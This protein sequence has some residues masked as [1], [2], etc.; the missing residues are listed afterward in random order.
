MLEDIRRNAKITLQGNVINCFSKQFSVFLSLL[1]F[2]LSSIVCVWFLIIDTAPLASIG[3]F[4]NIFLHIAV[5]AFAVMENLILFSVY[6]YSKLKADAYFY[7]LVCPC[8]FTL[9]LKTVV[10]YFSVFLAEKI[11]KISAFV[12]FFLPCGVVFHLAVKMLGTGVSKAIFAILIS[13]FCILLSLSVYSYSVFIC[14]YGMLTFVVLSDADLSVSEIFRTSQKLTNGKCKMSYKLK[15]NNL[16]RY[17][18]CLFIFPAVYCLPY[19]KMIKNELLMEDKKP[20]VPKKAHTEK[21]IVFYFDPV[22]EI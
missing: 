4:D 1:L 15:I 17:L 11:C 2:V 16:P 19:C 10:K 20:Y 14:K 3:V 6:L 21:S 7:K 13:C 12:M 8:N 9:N 22:K 5:C 18:L